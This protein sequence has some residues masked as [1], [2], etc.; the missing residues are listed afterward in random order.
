[1]LLAARTTWPS[2]GRPAIWCSTFGNFD[3]RRVPLPAARMAIAKL[4]F[5]MRDYCKAKA[6]DGPD[7][8]CWLDVR[9][10]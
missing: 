1:M 4:G 2:R 3:L 5:G 7:S 8:R 6:L 10:E 9:S